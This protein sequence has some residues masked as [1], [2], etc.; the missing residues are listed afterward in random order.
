[1][2]QAQYLQDWISRQGKIDHLPLETEYQAEI[3]VQ[4]IEWTM[5]CWGMALL[6]AVGIIVL[7]II[8]HSILMIWR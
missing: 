5:A 8:A 2:N 4:A 7:S 1:M 3:E 6:V